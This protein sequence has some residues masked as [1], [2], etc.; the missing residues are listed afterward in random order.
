MPNHEQIYQ[1]KADTY[2][3]LI[4]REDC[5]GN[6][7]KALME[8]SPFENLDII[9]MG[10][11]SGRLS[12]L[13]T[14]YA[15]SII[16]LDE[17]QAMLELAAERLEKSGFANWSTAV[18]DHRTLPL[19]DNS[20][21]AVTAGW[22]LCYLAS[23]NVQDWK[24]NIKAVLLEIERV[25]RPGGTFIILE[26]LG[27]GFEE[28]NAPDFLTEYYSLLQEQY[29]FS[30]KWIRTDY[31]FESIEEAHRLTGFF[32]GDSLARK[33]ISEK[34]TVLPEC[35]GIWCKTFS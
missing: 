24:D 29:G 11:G 17:S 14:P 21:D 6:I 7:L 27:T 3:L 1:T 13:L 35:T 34:L 32:F 4:S 19:N 31:K 10:A 20:A 12:C 18:S 9:D 25:L 26:T 23:S 33:V 15:K 2:E 5:E 30:Y 28:P 22:T 8:I 16:A